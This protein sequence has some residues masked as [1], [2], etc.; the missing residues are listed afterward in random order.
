MT[1]IELDR[2]FESFS[3][4][5]EEDSGNMSDFIS[6][7]RG[8]MRW[9][10]LLENR[11]IAVLGEAGTGKTTE[12]RQQVQRLRQAG[13]RA[14]FIAM[15]DL[16]DRRVEVDQ[17]QQ[18]EEWK[19][20]A[21]DAHFFLDSVDE[22]RLGHPSALRRALDQLAR[23]LGPAG[24]RASVLVSCRVSDWQ[25]FID[26]ATLKEKLTAFVPIGDP[27]SG[28]G[29][30]VH[31]IDSSMFLVD[32][33]A[34][35]PLADFQGHPEAD[36]KIVKMSPLDTPRI[37]RLAAAWEINDP[38]HFL[39]ALVQHGFEAF[40]RR[41]RDLEWLARYWREHHEFGDLSDMVELNVR[42]KLLEQNPTRVALGQE[43]SPQRARVGVEALAAALLLCE[44]PMI[45]LPNPEMDRGL[46][47]RA[48]WPGEVLRDWTD[49]EVQAL[50]TR[51]IFD[52]ATYGRVRFHD[53]SVADYLA[54]RWMADIVKK[55]Q[56]LSKV[57]DLV[58]GE[59]F[60]EPTPIASKKQI[61]GWLAGMVPKIRS[62]AIAFAPDVALYCGDSKRIPP[63]ERLLAL[64]ALA[65][66]TR[67]SGRTDWIVY[68]S[69][70]R[71][72][73]SP[74]MGPAI[75]ELLGTEA[76]NPETSR[77]LLRMVIL[78]GYAEAAE[79]ALRIALDESHVD[80]KR[81]LA[82][83][84]VVRA[85]SHMQVLE[86]RRYALETDG[87]SNGLLAGFCDALFPDVIDVDECIEIARCGTPEEVGLDSEIGTGLGWTFSHEI[88]EKCPPD[89]IAPLLS[90]LVDMAAELP[91]WNVRGE[92]L[93]SERYAWTLNPIAQALRRLLEV[94][95][96]SDYPTGTI[97]TALILLDKC[98]NRSEFFIS[99]LEGLSQE[100]SAH[101][102][103][104]RLVYW[105]I[106]RERLRRPQ[107]SAWSRWLM[108]NEIL[109]LTLED[110][111]WLLED[112]RNLADDNELRAAFETLVSLW[113]MEGRREEVAER[114]T[115]A[116]SSAAAGNELRSHVQECLRVSSREVSSIQRNQE[117]QRSEIE[118]SRRMALDRNRR[119]LLER[120][121]L[122]RD[123]SDFGALHFLLNQM[124]KS[125]NANR[126]SWGQTNWHTLIPKFGDEIAQ[127]ARDGF[128]LQW[129][130]WVPA[131]P[132][133][134]AGA[135]GVENGVPVGLTGL[136]IAVE[137]GLDLRSLAS[138]EARTAA[139]YALREINGFPGWFEI[140]ARAHSDVVLN[141]ANRQLTAELSAAQDVP[142]PG[143]FLGAIRR[144]PSAVKEL[145]AD[146]ILDQ[147]SVLEPPSI[148]AID[149]AVEILVQCGDD[150]RAALGAIAAG[151][152]LQHASNGDEARLLAWLIAWLWVDGSA[153]WQFIQEELVRRSER[154]SR[155][156][157]SISAVFGARIWAGQSIEDASFLSPGILEPMIRAVYA[158]VDPSDDTDPAMV[159]SADTRE[160]AEEFRN[161]LPNY[162]AKQRGAEAQKVLR[163]LANDLDPPELRRWIAGLAKRQAVI[164]VEYPPWTPAQVAEFGSIYEATPHQPDHLFAIALDRL[165]DIK[166]DIERGDFSDRELFVSG[167]PEYRVQLWLSG[168]LERESREHFNVVR[169]E[170]VHR[171]EATDIRLHN[172]TAGVVTIE[173][174][175]VDRSG[176][177]T[178][179]QLVQALEDQ[180]VGKY[181]RSSGS[182]HG[183]LVVTMLEKR[184]WRPN[185]TTG[186]IDFETMIQHL[187][188][189]AQEYSLTNP[190]VDALTVIG[191]DFT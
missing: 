118:A 152:A 84:A 179:S 58:L 86:L 19:S 43:I 160:M 156:V 4:A 107:R 169:E 167:M 80:S 16:A 141:A 51:A 184:R 120:V 89:R 183:I 91:I 62:E 177:Y 97:T 25:Y 24:R 153:A 90:A 122:L 50:L 67:I 137:D 105:S 83:E 166:D 154:P 108:S 111:S 52:P 55:G 76:D 44:Q 150:R 64:K 155:L 147:L 47:P 168:R 35:N 175:P 123:G 39:E 143:D 27:E 130:R 37:I 11:F 38:D 95:E 129:K 127:A 187:R 7:D 6:D 3:E 170:E 32:E 189:R 142:H 28:A 23:I 60:G 2:R 74:E 133:D 59:F 63:D 12:F 190:Y 149:D 163:S 148:R 93:I 36:L 119:T 82:A 79:S 56:R 104:H 78:G 134:R 157:A 22:A 135:S 92:D 117:Q 20:T 71:R 112:T 30:V 113:A 85:G 77:L 186:N 165:H 176:R 139:H 178:F 158:H 172:P 5:D 31:D 87:V 180:L 54:A 114:I 46:P 34:T 103:I 72:I 181:L 48:I 96:E 100:L 145:F 161:W 106:V 13:Q 115:Q 110:L 146:R 21:D 136:E 128:K 61:L 42:Q 10:A 9:S 174:K 17:E 162:L 191:I 15:E 131:L 94:S 29:D 14:F 182:R 1:Y 188:D 45:A 116:L 65:E 164:S 68:D 33:G 173:V 101:L 140:L 66:S 171:Q 53:P 151:S 49:R 75:A 125:G 102:S 138:D 41:P 88:I 185:R 124:R 109:D 26:P 144:G 121:D 132:C 40:A 70:V 57:R 126:S 99:S 69:D 81:T 18:I 73:L 8:Q 159:N 98:R